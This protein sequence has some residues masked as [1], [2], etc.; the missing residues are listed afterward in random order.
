M[1]NAVEKDQFLNTEKVQKH[2]MKLITEFFYRLKNG[3]EGLDN[4]AEEIVGFIN[5]LKER[6]RTGKML[7]FSNI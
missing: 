2:I 3:L 1:K 7:Q 4:L 6:D 5:K